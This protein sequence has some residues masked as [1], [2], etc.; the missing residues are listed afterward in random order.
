MTVRVNGSS[1]VRRGIESL[2]EVALFGGEDSAVGV[3][4]GGEEV[5]GD[6]DGVVSG[7]MSK[8]EISMVI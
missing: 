2:V 8:S 1:I 5:G 7:T 6:L 4:T 3:G